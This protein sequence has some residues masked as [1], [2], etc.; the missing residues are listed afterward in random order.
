MGHP[1]Y[2][3]H[4]NGSRIWTE[5]K[6]AYINQHPETHAPTAAAI[7]A[8]N[9]DVACNDMVEEAY[10]QGVQEDK[11]EYAKCVKRGWGFGHYC[12]GGRVARNCD[13][14]GARL[15]GYV[16]RCLSALGVGR[17]DWSVRLYWAFADCWWVW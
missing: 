14:C 6:W 4:P 12:V 8:L 16:L 7:Q 11:E 17:K 2:V 1:G 9:I 10:E 5:D 13:E 3:L 15:R